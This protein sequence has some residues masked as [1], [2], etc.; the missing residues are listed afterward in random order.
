MLVDLGEPKAMKAWLLAFLYVYVITWAEVQY[1]LCCTRDWCS[2]LTLHVV[3]QHTK[4]LLLKDI[5]I[6]H[7]LS[8]VY[9]EQEPEFSPIDTSE[10]QRKCPDSKVVR[11]WSWRSDIRSKPGFVLPKSL[12]QWLKCASTC[13]NNSY[14]IAKQNVLIHTQHIVRSLAAW[15]LV[16]GIMHMYI[17]TTIMCVFHAFHRTW[18][19]HL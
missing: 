9:R 10:Q 8:T 14:T 17:R 16:P 15:L 19:N 1:Q 18:L 5:I 2:G 7:F 6:N 3:Q 4:D 13:W 11:Y 12:F